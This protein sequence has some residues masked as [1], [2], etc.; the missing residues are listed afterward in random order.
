MPGKSLLFWSLLEYQTKSHYSGG[1][2]SGSIDVRYVPVN[3][4][5]NFGKFSVPKTRTKTNL[6][7]KHSYILCCMLLYAKKATFDLNNWLLVLYSSH[8]LNNGP[9]NF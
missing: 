2:D 3:P 8:N 6:I 7:H 9:F 1:I 4:W 5:L